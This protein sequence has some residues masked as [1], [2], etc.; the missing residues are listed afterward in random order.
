[1]GVRLLLVGIRPVC[2]YCIYVHKVIS[3]VYKCMVGFC[4]RVEINTSA[5]IYICVFSFNVF[6]WFESDIDE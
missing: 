5:V 4:Y 1:M 6:H 3:G 2:L